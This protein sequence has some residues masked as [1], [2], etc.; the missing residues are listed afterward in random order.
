MNS[1]N[2]KQKKNKKVKYC[3]TA[4]VLFLLLSAALMVFSA[5]VPAF[6]EW[7]SEYIYPLAV[8]SIGRIS[9]LV[10]FSVSEIGIYIL[11]TVFIVTLVRMVIK[12]TGSKAGRSK[13]GRRKTVD[14]PS[15]L[16]VSWF[17]FRVAGAVG[18]G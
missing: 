8:N 14:A 1:C 16:F 17:S 9:G 12:I 3:M 4:A 13:T 5:K 2:K 18:P 15:G 11:L 10:P 7:Y 6:A